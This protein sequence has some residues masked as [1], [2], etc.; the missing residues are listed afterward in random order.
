MHCGSHRCSVPTAHQKTI[1][2][3]YGHFKESWFILYM[4]YEDAL[5]GAQND[6]ILDYISF[7]THTQMINSEMLKVSNYL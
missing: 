2:C 3:D 7:Q 5:H 1:D 6:A 4:S